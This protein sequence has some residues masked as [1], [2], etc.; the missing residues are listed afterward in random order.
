VVVHSRN[1]ADQLVVIARVGVAQKRRAA[2]RMSAPMTSAT[3]DLE[4]RVTAGRCSDRA[5]QRRTVPFRC[6]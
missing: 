3:R 5:G 4:E 6:G 1:P 2:R